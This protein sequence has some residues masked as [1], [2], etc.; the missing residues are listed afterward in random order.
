MVRRGNRVHFASF[1]DRK[2]T[3]GA[4]MVTQKKLAEMLNVS[5]MTVSRVLRGE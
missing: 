4:R 5:Q 3:P 1:A 2:Q